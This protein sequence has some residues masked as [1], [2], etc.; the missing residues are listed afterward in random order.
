[1]RYK[2]IVM[3]IGLVG[4]AY[5]GAQQAGGAGRPG[6][7][8]PPN[9]T[10]RAREA[11]RPERLVTAYHEALAREDRYPFPPDRHDREARARA[12]DL[13][14]QLEEDRRRGRQI[15]RTERARRADRDT[16][17]ITSKK[18]PKTAPS[19]QI[20]QPPRKI[21]KFPY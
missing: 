13:R 3:M 18:A 20:K 14:A 17:R 19:P 2:V 1:M 21:P 11:D 8:G 10:R 12:E 4:I 16:K 9:E 15:D 7:L 5:T 6:P